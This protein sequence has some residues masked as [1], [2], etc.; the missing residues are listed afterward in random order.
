MVVP[1]AFAPRQNNF[2]PPP[3]RT[4]SNS[5]ASPAPEA[6]TPPPPAPRRQPSQPQYAE[7][8][9]E[10]EQ[11]DWVE[12]LYEYDSGVRWLS[13]PRWL[14]VLLWNLMSDAYILEIGSRRFKDNRRTEDPG[15][16]EDVG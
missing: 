14:L 15:G 4:A 10:E 12:A 5:S 11:G 13:G 1:S 8:E 7:P 6:A 16:G 3:R 2:A 9:A